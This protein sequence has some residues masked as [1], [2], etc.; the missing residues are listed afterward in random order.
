MSN[1]NLG[2]TSSIIIIIIVIVGF[3]F[4][5]QNFILERR[6]D[7]NSKLKKN[8][9]LLVFPPFSPSYLNEKKRRDGDIR[10][11]TGR[12]SHLQMYTRN[13]NKS[14]RQIFLILKL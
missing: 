9:Q 14:V 5:L 2:E 10:W 6:K 8:F 13:P 7:Q 11:K 3:F 1:F 4:N 12:I